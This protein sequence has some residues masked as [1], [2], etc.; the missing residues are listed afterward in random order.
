MQEMV[1]IVNLTAGK[2][3][4]ERLWPHIQTYLQEL[5]LQ[6]QVHFTQGEGDATQIA[7]K[8]ASD[9]FSYILSVG[10]DGTLNEIVNGIVGCP[11]VTLGIIPAGS[12]NDFV[13]TLGIKPDDWQAACR[14][15]KENSSKVIDLG[16]VNGRYFINVSGV[17]FDAA[18]VDCA[19]TWGKAHFKGTMAYV[20]AVIKTLW[21]FQAAQFTIE[22][23]DQVVVGPSW[24]TAVANGQYFGGGMWV[25]PNADLQDGYFD[26]CVLGDLS[27]FAFLRS[28]PSVFSG[29]HLQHPAIKIYRARK[30]TVSVD[31]P[32]PI[33]TDGDV[34]AKT[35]ITFSVCPNSLRIFC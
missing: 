23:D 6:L 27:K 14:K 31:R 30:V 3:K 34:V 10:G 22:L 28:F 26:V 16:Q 20:A 33:Q 5:G 1:A 32:L 13:R 12:G 17:G 25:A 21:E 24:L 15:I 7:K 18:V 11:H 19:N 8:A 35:P 29:K 9:G 2:G 4:C